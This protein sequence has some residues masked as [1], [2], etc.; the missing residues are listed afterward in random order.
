MK[1]NYSGHFKKLP[2]EVGYTKIHEFINRTLSNKYSCEYILLWRKTESRPFVQ[3][4][5]GL[6]VL[7]VIMWCCLCL[8]TAAKFANYLARKR[9]SSLTVLKIIMWYMRYLSCL[10]Y[11]Q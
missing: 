7:R 3:H 1:K 5:E 8:F 9:R 2:R 4:L 11:N 10:K 6:R